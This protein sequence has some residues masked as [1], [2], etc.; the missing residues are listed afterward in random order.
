MR[1]VVPFDL[2]RCKTFLRSSHM[3][4][5]DRDGVVE[6][7]DLAHA[8]DGLCSR[9]VQALHPTAED[10]RLREGRDLHAGRPNVDAIDG[11]SVDLCRVST[12]LAGVPMSLKSSGVLSTTFSGT[13]M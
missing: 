2:E 7:H 4:G 1:T 13:G 11:R 6:P 5:H 10:G 8:L 9:I 12:R 3:V